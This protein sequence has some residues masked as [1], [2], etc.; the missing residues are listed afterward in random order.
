MN[1]QN[2]AYIGVVDKEKN[3]YYTV[4]HVHVL[5]NS[6]GKSYCWNINTKN[7]T[8]DLDNQ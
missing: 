8:F 3:E 5:G 4:T 6:S 7:L 1:D 2:K